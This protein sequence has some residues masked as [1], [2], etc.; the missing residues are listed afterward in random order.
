MNKKPKAVEVIDACCLKPSLKE[1]PLLTPI[2]AGGLAA[3]VQG[4][5]QRH[6]PASSARPGPGG[7]ALRQ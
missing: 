3:G 2:Q 4:P 5:G 6:P 1:R 7:R